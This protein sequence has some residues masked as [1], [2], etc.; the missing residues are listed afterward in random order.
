MYDS[1]D[2]L[3]YELLHNLWAASSAP[4]GMMTEIVYQL[5]QDPQY[6][7]PL[8][9]EAR[10]AV[11]EFGWSEKMLARLH[12]QDSFIREVNRLLPTGSSS[13]PPDCCIFV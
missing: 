13:N 4:G 2:H 7:E 3:T 1:V 11:D 6:I 10:K 12:L 9:H 5:L 8:R